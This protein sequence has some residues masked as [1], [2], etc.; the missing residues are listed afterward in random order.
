MGSN[1]KFQKVN[2]VLAAKS[3]F[4]IKWSYISVITISRLQCCKVKG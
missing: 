2:G 3:C 4:W 1:F